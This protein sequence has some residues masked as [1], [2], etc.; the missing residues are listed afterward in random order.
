MSS[1]MVA[2]KSRVWRCSG[3]RLMMRRTSGRKP[4]S[5]MRSASSSTST[6]TPDRSTVPWPRWSRSRPGQATTIS[7][8][9]RKAWICGADANAAVDGDAAQRGLPP[10]SANDWWICSASS[11]VGA[12]TRARARRRGP[13]RAGAAGSAGRTPRSCRCRSG[14][15]PCTS[16]PA[17]IGRDRLLLDGGRLDDSRGPDRRLD[18]GVK[19]KRFE[20]QTM[21]FSGNRR[22]RVTG[23]GLP[24]RTLRGARS[25]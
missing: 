15:G 6:S 21:S 11:R 19:L 1:G 18:V 25:N 24:R 8:P 4:M 23:L 9:A 7:A 5:N 2:E 17:M 12:T 14:P 22:V 16:R 13:A 3:R 10:R 20:A